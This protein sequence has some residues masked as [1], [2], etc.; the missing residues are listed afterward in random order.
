MLRNC[1]SF[2]SYTLPL[3]FSRFAVE[4]YAVFKVLHGLRRGGDGRIRTGD[5]LLA[6]QVLFQLSYTPTSSGEA[7]GLK[8]TRTTDLTLIR[9][10]L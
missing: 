8:W 4:L 9:R 2:R 10:A 5:P 3:S 6:R 7:G 1:S